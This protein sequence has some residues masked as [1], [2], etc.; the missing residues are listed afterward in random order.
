MKIKMFV[1]LMLS[2]RVNARDM[3]HR[4]HWKVTEDRHCVLCLG[5]HEDN[6]HLF[7]SLQFQCTNLEL[8]SD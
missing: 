8:S 6:Y 4:R 3:L 5:V 1:W 2:D 7:F